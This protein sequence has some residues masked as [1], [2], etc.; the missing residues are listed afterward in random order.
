MK[1]KGIS[2][3]KETQIVTLKNIGFC[4]GVKNAVFLSLKN[5]KN[6]YSVGKV[7]HNKTV[8]Q[9]LQKKGLRIID[10]ISKVPKNKKI[11][12]RSHGE[13]KKNYE[14]ANEMNLKV[15][16]TVCP[17][18]LN[19]RKLI[20]SYTK[21]GYIPLIAGDKH[22]PEVK[23]LLSFSSKKGYT[24][25]N[26]K[27]YKNTLKKIKLDSKNIETGK[28]IKIILISQTTF[29]NN[30]L[31]EIS[32]IR[33]PNSFEILIKNTICPETIRRQKDVFELAK[34]LPVIIIIGDKDSSNSKKLFS[35]A[36]KI[37][38]NTFFIENLLDLKDRNFVE[39]LKK[40]NKIGIAAGAS[41][42]EGIIKNIKEEIINVKHER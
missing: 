28:K 34:K 39:T 22:H 11:I 2:E 4:N 31:D 42:P 5:S 8:N 24:F 10:D 27:E 17:F 30:I 23:G 15:I 7:V 6:S 18:V 32:K 14:I 40:Y 12:F 26:V 38:K 33:I 41:V 13:L 1:S 35:I 25:S 19:I 36:N 16:D 9:D 20:I 21:K 3:N 29:N 37:N